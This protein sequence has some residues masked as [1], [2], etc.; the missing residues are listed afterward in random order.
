MKE[1]LNVVMVLNFLVE[2]LMLLGAGRLAGF[3]VRIGRAVLA[4]VLGAVYA[5]AC[6]VPSFRFLG[7]ML[8]RTVSLAWMGVLAF[9]IR[10]ETLRCTVLFM[11]LSMALDGIAQ[12][13]GRGSVGSMLLGAVGVFAMCLLGF[14][15]KAGQSFLP[16][17]LSRNG[18]TACLTALIDTGNMLTDPVTGERVLVVGAK[19]AHKL[20]GL[21][22]QQLSQ[23][24]QTMASGCVQGLRLIPYRTVG[25]SSGMLLAMRFRNARLGRRRSDILVAFAPEGLEAGG[26]Q[27]L[28]GGMV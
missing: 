25:Q 28:I 5:G 12:G 20:T 3:P 19:T 21:T 15:G 26:Y 2:L 10:C 23:P 27:A 9:G 6:M 14:Q 11:L 1:Y 7:N 16:V 17:E 22:L 18:T 8:W 24:V 4:A 13:L